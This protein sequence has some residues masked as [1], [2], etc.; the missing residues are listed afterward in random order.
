MEL[1]CYRN[2]ELSRESRSLPADTYNLAYAMLS[3]SPTGCMFVPIR[4]MQTL[5]ILDSEEMVFVDSARKCWI[6]IAW[7][8]FN[9]QLRHS[10]LD[11]VPYQA[12]FYHPDAAQMMARLQTEFPRAL[13]QLDKKGRATGAAKVLKFPAP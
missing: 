12:V 6:D 10:L 9:P 11:P 1:V 13:L 8:D 4:S 7:R 3:R 5:A 2:P